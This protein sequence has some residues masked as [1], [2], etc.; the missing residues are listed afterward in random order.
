MRVQGQ[1]SA[2]SGILN[3]LQVNGT[4][5]VNSTGKILAAPSGPGNTNQAALTQD[6]FATANDLGIQ[7]SALNSD[8]S[9]FLGAGAN[10]ISW[11]T[12]GVLTVPAAVIG[13]LTIASV[14]AGVVGGAYATA[15]G[16]GARVIF[17]TAGIQAFNSSNVQTV[18]LD[19]TTGNFTITG[20]F[21]LQSPTGSAQSVFISNTGI[22]L[23]STSGVFG[24]T[25]K[26]DNATSTVGSIY[27]NLNNL[28]VAQGSSSSAIGSQLIMGAT[29]WSLI[30]P[31]AGSIFVTGN[32]LQ[33]TGA[34]YPGQQASYG[35]QS[36]GYVGW[37]SSFSMVVVGG[38]PLA[39]IGLIYPGT[40]S[41]A[42][43][44]MSIQ[45]DTGLSST[46]KV[47]AFSIHLTGSSGDNFM[48]VDSCL[49]P[50]GT[51][52]PTATL[53]AGVAGIPMFYNGHQVHLAA[54]Q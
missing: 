14:G 48:E 21:T 3:T 2:D 50:T 41:A 23:A 31:N 11:T 37:L 30:S 34:I 27:S 19:A 4:L 25:I 49:A 22:V 1:I 47:N 6:G 35:T 5:N 44:T 42:Q 54:Y 53:P 38:A 7:T 46:L 13:S 16:T 10:Q 45:A 15:G 52:P 8:G 40:G 12:A 29:D 18:N 39:T 43:N 33:F 51:F 28:V 32:N 20:V 9:G 17:S 36:T 26:W 24:D